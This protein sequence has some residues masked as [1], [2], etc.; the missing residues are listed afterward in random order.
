LR[1]LE[2]FFVTAKEPAKSHS[3]LVAG[4]SAPELGRARVRVRLAA[5][6]PNELSTQAEECGCRCGPI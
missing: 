4:G 6:P 3:D 2:F 5:V 1:Y